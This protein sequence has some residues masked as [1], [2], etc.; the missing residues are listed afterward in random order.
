MVFG[1]SKSNPTS[2]SSSVMDLCDLMNEESADLDVEGT[3]PHEIN[4]IAQNPS[5]KAMLKHPLGQI[6]LK[7]QATNLQ[8]CKKNDINPS[9]CNLQD[10]CDSFLDVVSFQEKKCPKDARQLCTFS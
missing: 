3:R 6:L 9:T 5:T 8:L 1:R 2:R 10:L 4:D 7:I